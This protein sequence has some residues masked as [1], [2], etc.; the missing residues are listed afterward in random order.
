MEMLLTLGYEVIVSNSAIEAI[1]TTKKL[2]EKKQPPQLL[3]SDIIMPG[4]INGI[5]LARELRKLIPNL[6]VLLTT[7]YAGSPD[8][9]QDQGVE[10]EVLTKPYKMAD[11]AKKV[12]SVL[13]GPTVL[14]NRRK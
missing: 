9:E 10:F 1:N 14:Q 6:P 2:V 3:F 13:E 11:L 4:G 12:R 8:K 7:G 5:M